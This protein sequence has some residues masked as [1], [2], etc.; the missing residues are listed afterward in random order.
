MP[1]DPLKPTPISDLPTAQLLEL[2][3]ELTAKQQELSSQWAA[4]K[5]VSL[6]TGFATRSLQYWLAGKTEPQPRNRL[7]LEYILQQLLQ[8][9]ERRARRGH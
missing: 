8:D 4:L 7:A 1:D 5:A 3:L 9:A 2:L 6:Q